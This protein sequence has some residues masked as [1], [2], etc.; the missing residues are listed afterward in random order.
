MSL[1]LS[2]SFSASVL[3]I[4]QQNKSYFALCTNNNDDMNAVSV[5]VCVC[6]LVE[7]SMSG[8]CICFIVVV[9]VS[10]SELCVLCGISLC[11][12]FHLRWFRFRCVNVNTHEPYPLVAKRNALSVYMFLIY[13]V[14]KRIYYA[15]GV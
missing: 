6:V 12:W 9:V 13:S 1:S 5:S 7:Q 4:N 8:L 15:Y 10:S 11:V 3:F 2:V 14:L